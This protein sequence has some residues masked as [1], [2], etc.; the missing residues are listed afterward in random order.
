MI[1]TGT[2]SST[3]TWTGKG[4]SNDQYEDRIFER[5]IDTKEN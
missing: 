5:D 1:I 3:E 2:G 4:T